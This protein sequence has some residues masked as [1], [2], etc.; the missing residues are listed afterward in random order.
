VSPDFVPG[1]LGEKVNEGRIPRSR[2]LERVVRVATSGLRA[3]GAG[4]VIDS[5]KRA[6]A[7]RAV[8]AGN[9]RSDDAMRIDP[10]LVERLRRQ[11]AP[12]VARLERLLGRD[13]SVWRDSGGEAR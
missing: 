10:S 11:F 2:G 5:L 8:R 9:S 6:G 13:L 1:G 12:D 3:V 4:R 7:D